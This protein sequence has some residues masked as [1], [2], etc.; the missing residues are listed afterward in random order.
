MILFYGS[1]KLSSF[2]FKKKFFKFFC[3]FKY[4]YYSANILFKVKYFIFLYF[5]FFSTLYF[6]F[7]Y[8]I[9][10]F[11]GVFSGYF[12]GLMLDDDMAYMPSY[13][14]LILS[15][16]II[17]FFLNFKNNN[18]KKLLYWIYFFSITSLCIVSYKLSVFY[19]IRAEFPRSDSRGYFSNIFSLFKAYLIPYYDLEGGIFSARRYCDQTWENSVYIGFIALILY[20]IFQK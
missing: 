16:F 4:F 19:E 11:A 13:C 15:I 14:I 17:N 3:V 2:Y 18:R 9:C 12:F 20:I 6:L 10:K 1:Y 8:K 5:F 7:K